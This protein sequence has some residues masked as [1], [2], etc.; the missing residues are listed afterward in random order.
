MFT[1]DTIL[2]FSHPDIALKDCTINRELQEIF[3]WFKANKLCVNASKTNYMV[4][5]TQNKTSKIAQ[6][7]DMSENM[8]S[9]SSCNADKGSHEYYS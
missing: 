4:L 6:L 5:G 1:N 3:N 7:N 9:S 2:L 8:Q